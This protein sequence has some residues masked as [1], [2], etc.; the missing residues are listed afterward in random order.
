[1]KHMFLS[2]IVHVVDDD[3]SF[4]ISIQRRL[5][6]SGFSVLTYASAEQFLDQHR[7]DNEESG[8]ILLDVDL[9]GLSGPEVQSRLNELGSTLPIVF[10]SGNVDASVAETVMEAGAEDFLLKPINSDQLIRSIRQA[11]ARHERAQQTDISVEASEELLLRAAAAIAETRLLRGE[12]QQLRKDAQDHMAQRRVES[13]FV[14]KALQM[15]FLQKVPAKPMCMNLASVCQIEVAF[16]PD[17]FLGAGAG[18][19]K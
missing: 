10:L 8:C 3:A 5:K 17:G 6:A 9:P 13:A 14:P 4:R 1:M 12:S 16:A 2:T 19:E 18:S 15:Y 11:I 7:S